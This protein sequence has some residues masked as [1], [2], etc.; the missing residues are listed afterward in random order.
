MV[1]LDFFPVYSDECWLWLSACKFVTVTRPR[2]MR[3]PRLKGLKVMK[4]WAVCTCSQCQQW[5]LPIFTSRGRK[6]RIENKLAIEYGDAMNRLHFG[7][8]FSRD[9][10]PCLDQLIRS[11]VRLFPFEVHLLLFYSALLHRWQLVAPEI[12]ACKQLQPLAHPF[13]TDWRHHIHS[14][15][16]IL[17]HPSVTEMSLA[18]SWFI[19]NKSKYF[20]TNHPKYDWRGP[21]TFPV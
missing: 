5:V 18:C 19:V 7:F 6:R 2:V 10:W 11:L 8:R 1:C 17:L 13:T 3:A 9:T 15:R 21:F 12:S 4:I 16:Q 14:I 20:S